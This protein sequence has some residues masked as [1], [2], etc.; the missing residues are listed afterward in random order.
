M[1][2]SYNKRVFDYIKKH[3]LSDRNIISQDGEMSYQ[4]VCYAL[5]SLVARGTIKKVRCKT[6]YKHPELFYVGDSVPEH[7]HPLDPVD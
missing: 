3:P 7:P 4:K 5:D 6:C 1:G 2:D